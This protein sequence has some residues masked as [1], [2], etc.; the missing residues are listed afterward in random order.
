MQ[1]REDEWLATHEQ[2]RAA[3]T[4][5]FVEGIGQGISHQPHGR[6]REQIVSR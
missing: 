2:T 3:V 4:E 5:T 6:H 1:R